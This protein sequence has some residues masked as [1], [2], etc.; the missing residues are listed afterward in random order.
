MGDVAK[1]NKVQ[2]NLDAVLRDF[3]NADAEED[4][5]KINSRK[6]LLKVSE[7]VVLFKGEDHRIVCIVA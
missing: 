6:A 1:Q 5:I 7:T 2:E 3:Y 4:D